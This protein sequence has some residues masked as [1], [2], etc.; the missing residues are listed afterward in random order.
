[1]WEQ[2]AVHVLLQQL[3]ALPEGLLGRQV[4]PALTGGVTEALR[5][6]YWWQP[7]QRWLGGGAELMEEL[8]LRNARCWG[9]GDELDAYDMV[10]AGRTWHVSGV[11]GWGPGATLGLAAAG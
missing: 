6:E 4:V 7:Q 3:G 11:L 5:A 2:V 10:G 1:M 9:A 8:L